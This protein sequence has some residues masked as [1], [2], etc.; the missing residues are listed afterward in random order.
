[1]N[2]ERPTEAELLEALKEVTRRLAWHVAYHGTKM[3][4]LV[5]GYAR[6][7]IAKAEGE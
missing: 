2:N 7:V 5:V 3:D 4:E 6:E 1:M